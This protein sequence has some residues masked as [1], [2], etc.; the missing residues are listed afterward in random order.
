MVL[1]LNDVIGTATGRCWSGDAMRSGLGLSAVGGRH[2]VVVVI[3]A[4]G[5][6]DV[7]MGETSEDMLTM[8]TVV[9]ESV[10]TVVPVVLKTD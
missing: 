2:T 3:T 10:V 6:D 9:L 4:R 1:N 8:L 5:C 7:V